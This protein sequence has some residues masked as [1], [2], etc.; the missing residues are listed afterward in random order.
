MRGPVGKAR[1]M[2]AVV[3]WRWSEPWCTHEGTQIDMRCVEPKRWAHEVREGLRAAMWRA[4]AARRSDMEG[5]G[6]GVGAG[7]SPGAEAASTA[8]LRA[9]RVGHLATLEPSSVV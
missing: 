9:S 4:A 5:I 3:L 1:K 6:D 7:G 2:F 8:S